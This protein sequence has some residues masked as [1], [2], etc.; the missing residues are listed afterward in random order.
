MK[1]RSRPS[2][3]PGSSAH[4]ESVSFCCNYYHAEGISWPSLTLKNGSNSLYVSLPPSAPLSAVPSPAFGAS[5]LWSSLTSLMMQYPFPYKPL[6]W[7]FA[8]LSASQEES[9]TGVARWIGTCPSMQ[10]EWLA[11]GLLM[12]GHAWEGTRGQLCGFVEFSEWLYWFTDVTLWCPADGCGAL[13]PF[14]ERKLDIF[15]SFWEESGVYNLVHTCDS[16]AIQD[17]KQLLGGACSFR[18]VLHA[19]E[20][21]GE[22][23][24]HSFLKSLQCSEPRGSSPRP[25]AC[26]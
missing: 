4:R 18:S 23:D 5:A 1:G 6:C 21:S 16:R 22:E 10:G 7:K 13:S 8:T 9:F 26:L 3:Q 11:L 12:W 24:L 19:M 17:K 20:G 15:S 25:W 2:P 14:G